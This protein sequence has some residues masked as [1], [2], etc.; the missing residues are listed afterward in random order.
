MILAVYG[1]FWSTKVRQQLLQ[2]ILIPLDHFVPREDGLL[3]S[4]H[5]NGAFQCNGILSGNSNSNMSRNSA[6]NL[7]TP[8]SPTSLPTFHV[9][10]SSKSDTW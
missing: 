3:P 8:P 2:L 1:F 10:C 7:N 6:G 4:S 5:E 9:V